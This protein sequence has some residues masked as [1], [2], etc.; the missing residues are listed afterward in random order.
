[1]LRADAATRVPRARDGRPARRATCRPR[2]RSRPPQV[3]LVLNVGKAHIGE[4]GSQQAI[5]Q[6]KGEIVEALPGRRAASRCSTPTTRWSPRWPPGPPARVSTFGT[7]RDADVR[8]ERRWRSTTSAG[9]PSTLV[10]GDE[11]RHACRCGL[12]GEHHAANAAAV[13]AVALAA[14]GVALD[15]VAGALA[16]A[17]ATSRGRMELHERAD[18][19]T[20]STTPTTP[21]RTRCGPRSRRWPRSA[22]AGPAPRTIAVLGEML[23]LGESAAARSTTRSADWPCAWTSTSCSSSAR[24]RSR[25]TSAPAWRAPG[26]ASR[27]SCRTPTPRSAGCASNLVRRGRR[28]VQVVQGRAGAAGWRTR[29]WPT[30]R[31]RGG[32]TRPK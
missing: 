2:A 4:F 29:C 27:S 22:A 5:A 8:F 18:G 9:R 3:S 28:A 23:E 11:R 6:A 31:R 25:S 13:A 16:T 26:A 21:T 12:I 10:V 30:D 14:R 20:V 1:M 17:T 19:V 32:T 7:G 15:A 24:G